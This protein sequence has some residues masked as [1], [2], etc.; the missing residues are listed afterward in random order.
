MH[1]NF[2]RELIDDTEVGKSKVVHR[3]E[4][5]VVRS[6]GGGCGQ[7]QMYVCLGGQG[8]PKAKR[9]LFV[10][11]VTGLGSDDPPRPAQLRIPDQIIL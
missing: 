5:E 3:V 1:L 10:K 2:G 11:E 9:N 8:S 7:F 6:L 4:N